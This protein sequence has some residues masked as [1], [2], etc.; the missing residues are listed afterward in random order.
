MNS[1]GGI[2]SRASSNGSKQ[3]DQPPRSYSTVTAG[4]G[5]QGSDWIPLVGE[6]KL[7]YHKPVVKDGKC[8][9]KLPSTV[10]ENASVLWDDSLI[11]QFMG[12]APS[13]NLIQNAA[14][15]LWGRKGPVTVMAMGKDDFIIK[16]SDSTTSDWVLNSGPWYV[17]NRPLFLRKY[18]KGLS[19]EKLSTSSYPIWIKIWNIPLD[20]FHRRY[21]VHSKWS[22]RSNLP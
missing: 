11:A 10:Y 12:S 9:I 21:W 18:E 14:T 19:I 3:A 8:L 17:G 20:F 22:W 5:N 16:F 6:K 2:P 1:S 4:H 15:M 7:S 13:L